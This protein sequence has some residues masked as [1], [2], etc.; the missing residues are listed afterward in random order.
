MSSVEIKLNQVIVI[1]LNFMRVTDLIQACVIFSSI[2]NSN[3]TR[4]VGC[5]PQ[6]MYLRLISDTMTRHGEPKSR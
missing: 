1:L 6:S 5:Q 3:E 2:K 4:A